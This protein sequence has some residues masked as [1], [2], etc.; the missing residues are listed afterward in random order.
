MFLSKESLENFSMNQNLKQGI[1][2]EVSRKTDYLVKNENKEKMIDVLGFSNSD[3]T[4]ITKNHNVLITMKNYKEV[5]LSAKKK[6]LDQDGLNCQLVCDSVDLQLAIKQ[7]TEE[8]KENAD[9]KEVGL[10]RNHTK[11]L[12][13][14]ISLAKSGEYQ[15]NYYLGVY[16]SPNMTTTLLIKGKEATKEQIA[17]LKPFWSKGKKDKMTKKTTNSGFAKTLDLSKVICY[18]NIGL[19]KLIQ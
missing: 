2:Y 3:I 11:T 4:S 10:R 7:A 9:T 8:C 16:E 14:V 19:D 13:G 18:R 12:S 1:S 17:S 6:E 5:L 15:M